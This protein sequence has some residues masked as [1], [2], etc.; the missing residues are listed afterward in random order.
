MNRAGGQGRRHR[1]LL[2]P[3][4]LRTYLVLLAISMGCVPFEQEYIQLVATSPISLSPIAV[5]KAGNGCRGWLAGQDVSLHRTSMQRIIT[6]YAFSV[7]LQTLLSFW[8]LP[9]LFENCIFYILKMR[10]S[11]RTLLWSSSLHDSTP[12][13]AQAA[14]GA[15]CAY[16]FCAQTTCNINPVHYTRL[17]LKKKKKYLNYSLNVDANGLDLEDSS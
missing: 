9:F 10:T 8:L 16:V 13:Q 1:Q 5:K 14:G 2:L 3:C 12:R 6:P 7:A 17:D 11:V 15:A 4:Y